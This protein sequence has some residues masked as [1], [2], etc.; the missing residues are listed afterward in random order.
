MQGNPLAVFTPVLMGEE[1]YVSRLPAAADTVPQSARLSS[2]VV[3]PTFLDSLQA[4]TAQ[5]ADVAFYRLLAL[6]GS[7]EAS[8]LRRSVRSGR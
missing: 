1:L 5:S 3:E 6:A 4:E 8:D 2:L 7:S